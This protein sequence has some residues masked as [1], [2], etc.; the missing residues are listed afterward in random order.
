MHCLLWE[1]HSQLL[2]PEGSTFVSH[3]RKLHRHGCVSLSLA[4]SCP[5]LIAG[6]SGIASALCR[7]CS[8]FIT[9][10]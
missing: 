3:M 6:V 8:F 10:W 9:Q 5:A 2:K 4:T 1:R 7:Q